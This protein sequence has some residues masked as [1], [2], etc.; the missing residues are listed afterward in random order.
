MPVMDAT[1][2]VARVVPAREASAAPPLVLLLHGIGADEHDLLPLARFL[3][4]RCQ[5][6][7][8]RAPR[9]YVVGHAWFPVDFRPDGSVVPDAAAARETLA[10]LQEWL[11]A[12]PARLGTDPARTFLLGFSQGAMM[13][14]GLLLTMP[15]RLAGVAALSGR[16][17][18]GLFAAT[19]PP[20]AIARVPLLVA[21]GLHDDVLP[22]VHGR[23][24]RDAFAGRI[25]D[26][27]YRELP[28]GHEISPAELDLVSG[29]LSARL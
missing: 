12:A 15:E 13:S 18:P 11:A 29:W 22:I 2:F 14:L 3:D 28:I 21:H 26:F 1:D 6:V 27:T 16:F 7:S 9:D 20:E 25:A 19:A 24:V 5:V 10:D 8:L 17:A 23:G 4:P